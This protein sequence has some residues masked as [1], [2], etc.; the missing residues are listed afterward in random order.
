MVARTTGFELKEF[1]E[2]PIFWKAGIYHGKEKITVNGILLQPGSEIEDIPDDAIVTVKSGFVT[3]YDCDDIDSFESY[4]K[5]WRKSKKFDILMVTCDKE[6]T[7][8]VRV[9]IIAAGGKIK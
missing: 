6:K 5:K 2:D 3:T 4:F 9:A 8:Q 1:Y 7:D